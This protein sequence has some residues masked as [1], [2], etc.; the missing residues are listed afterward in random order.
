MNSEQPKSKVGRP[1]KTPAELRAKALERL[2]RW[3]ANHR[4]ADWTP[5]KPGRKPKFA[6]DEERRAYKKEYAHQ[7]YLRKKQQK[8]HPIAA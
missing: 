5:S 1:R 3:K 8:Q 2:H 4:P 6:T 7:Y